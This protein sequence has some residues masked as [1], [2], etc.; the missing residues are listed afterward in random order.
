MII[1]IS[2]VRTV[3]S[4]YALIQ[5]DISQYGSVKTFIR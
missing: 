1:E 4:T 3:K 2:L 5:Q